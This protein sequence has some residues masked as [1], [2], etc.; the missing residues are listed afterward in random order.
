MAAADGASN[1]AIGR[2]LGVC[3]DTVRKWRRR[4]SRHGID[5]LCDRPGAGR[6][7]RF[8]A[9]A[10]AEVKALA[11]E[12]PT[13]SEVPLAKCSCPELA[14]EVARRGVVESV[15]ASTVRRWLAADVLKPWQHRSWIC[16]RD[17]HFAVKAA[18]V[19]DLSARIFG[20][21]QMVCVRELR[22]RLK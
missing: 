19:L 7:R 3:D 10:V 2:T 8:S 15:S 14:T 21:C 11:C 22:L 5:G 17:P 1:A 20:A 4:F 18:R 12:L 6:P 16:P 9:A 13:N